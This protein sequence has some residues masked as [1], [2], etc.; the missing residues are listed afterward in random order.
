MRKFFTKTLLT[1]GIVYLLS[2]FLLD[3]P[4]NEFVI[5]DFGDQDFANVGADATGRNIF[6]TTP[7]DGAHNPAASAS[8]NSMSWNDTAV[9]W[10]FVA[11]GNDAT[12]FFNG[13][14]LILFNTRCILSKS[15]LHRG[16]GG[17]PNGGYVV[18]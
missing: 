11:D 12:I 9:R 16:V 15:R 5:I 14:N 17:R 3:R 4:L 10:S 1:E 2:H 13:T 8:V 7:L 6:E 18:Y